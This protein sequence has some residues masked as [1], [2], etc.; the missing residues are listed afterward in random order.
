MGCS[1][2]QFYRCNI[3]C[4]LKEF[5]DF[6]ERTCRVFSSSQNMQSKNSLGWVGKH[7]QNATPYLTTTS[8]QAL[9]FWGAMPPSMSF[10]HHKTQKVAIITNLNIC[11]LHTRCRRRGGF[12]HVLIRREI[13][14]TPK[15]Q[16]KDM[17]L[18]GG[19]HFQNVGLDLGYYLILGPFF[20][21]CLHLWKSKPTLPMAP[22]QS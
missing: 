8:S 5:L 16:A 15:K 2:A 13:S 20:W 18:H 17:S 22:K 9:F 14:S 11:R 1:Y 7:S 12:L 10:T 3:P 4:A 6:S 21:E 19:V